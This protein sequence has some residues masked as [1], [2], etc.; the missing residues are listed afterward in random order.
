MYRLENETHKILWYPE[1]KA[2]HPIPVRRLYFAV[3]NKKKQKRQLVD[4]AVPANYEA[5]VK[6]SEK[7]G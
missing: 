5:N 3:I 1:T 6:E 7:A 4:F 2:Y